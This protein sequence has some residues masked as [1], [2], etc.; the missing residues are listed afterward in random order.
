MT[1]RSPRAQRKSILFQ[2]LAPSL[3]LVVLGF[4]AVG[5]A[6]AWSRAQSAADQFQRR[7]EQSASLSQ[8]ST[9]N[10][11]WELDT[12]ALNAALNPIINDPDQRL[13]W[14]VDVAGR[15]F[16][17]HGHDSLLNLAA[18]TVTMADPT[19]RPRVIRRGDYLISISPLRREE[20]GAVEPLGDLVVVYDTRSV[21]TAAW[22]AVLWVLAIGVVV[23]GLV[24]ALLVVLMRRIAQPIDELSLAMG[25]LSQG[26]LD[27]EIAAL[28][29]DD[30]I[31]AMARSVQVFKDNAI[32]LK[33]TEDE[34]ARLLEARTRAEAS[35]QAKS[36]FLANMSHELRTPLNGVLTMAQLMARG[37][38]DADQRDKLEV[39]LRSGQDLLHVIN[40]VLDFSKIEAGK[41][42]LEHTPFQTEELFDAVR[43]GFAV[44][45][46]RKALHLTLRVDETARG[47]RLGDPARLRQIVNNFVSNA[48]KFTTEGGVTIQA[49]GQGEDGQDGLLIAVQDTGPGI[50]AEGVSRLFQKFSQV[51]ASTTRKFGGTGLGLAICHELAGLMGGRV[52]V[53]STPGL[54]STFYALVALP[55]CCGDEALAAE[56]EGAMPA[57]ASGRPL[58]ILAAE[59]NANNHAVLRAIMEAFGFDLTLAVNGREA[60]EAWRHAQFDL[61]LMDVQ[62]PEMDGVEATRAIRAAEVRQGVART[63]IIAL[64]ANAFR[65]QIEAYE[66]AGMDDHLSKPIDITAL[67]R[68]IARCLAEPQDSAAAASA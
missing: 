38:L 58:R 65:H 3:M 10:S 39:I 8:P 34:R 27:T 7:V 31:G 18:R 5:V 23:I 24:V 17:V 15:T 12:T 54:G 19:G 61:I 46:E 21:T 33:E 43:A 67:Q 56:A 26:Q 30:E 48:I 47:L 37:D 1:A 11:V 62:M 20:F 64:T 22:S 66:A 14:V 60:V 13:V 44:Q 42:E 45:A 29:R 51:D 4:L 40:D 6:T 55:R 9:A 53:E 68:V 36:E 49:R 28:S 2:V 25:A 52:W 35:N 59:D 32:R 63:P 16:F 57:Q 41:L 50:T